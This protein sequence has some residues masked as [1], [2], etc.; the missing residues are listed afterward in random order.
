MRA[1][2]K[3]LLG[4]N[5]LMLLVV[6]LWLLVGGNRR[7]YFGGGAAGEVD[8]I[9]ILILALFNVVYLATVFFS[10]PHRPDGHIDTVAREVAGSPLAT[11][12][13]GVRRFLAGLSKYALGMNA[14]VFLCVGLWL[15]V[16][17]GRWGYFRASATEVDMIVLFALSLTNV[18]F[19]AAAWVRFSRQPERASDGP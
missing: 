18:A 17:S 4:F 14:L 15:M 19:M 8:G 3:A 7:G 10:L 16:S 13:V 12:D 9:L 2:A 11:T 6:C 5:G 1:L